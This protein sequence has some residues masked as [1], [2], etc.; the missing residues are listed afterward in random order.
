ML[1]PDAEVSPAKVRRPP[2]DQLRSS[3]RQTPNSSPPQA[4]R[5]CC[6]RSSDASPT[7][8]RDERVTTPKV[9]VRWPTPSP[10]AGPMRTSGDRDHPTWTPSSLT[11]GSTLGGFRFDVLPTDPPPRL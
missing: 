1:E 7:T 11:P 4:K 9:E 2:D 8:H 10:P 3:S 5:H 6:L